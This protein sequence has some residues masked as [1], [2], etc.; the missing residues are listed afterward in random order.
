MRA[1]WI[2]EIVVGLGNGPLGPQLGDLGGDERLK[3][4]AASMTPLVRIGAGDIEP[5]LGAAA[6]RSSDRMAVIAEQRTDWS[7]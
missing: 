5:V 7:W 3:L 2:A 4:D 1:S 6:T